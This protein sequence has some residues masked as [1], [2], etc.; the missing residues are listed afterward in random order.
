[1]PVIHPHPANVRDPVFQIFAEVEITAA[2]VRLTDQN[3]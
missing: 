2:A 1:L 3:I